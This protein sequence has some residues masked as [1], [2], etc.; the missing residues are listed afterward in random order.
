MK[1]LRVLLA[2]DHTLVRAGLRSLLQQMENVEVVAEAEDGRQVLAAV[3]EHRPDVVLMDISMSG[4]NGLE[5]T[6]QLKRDRPEVRVIILSMHATEEYVLQA[7]RAGAS[8]YLLKD[9]A[10]LELALALQAVARG[11]SYLSPPVSRQVV[12][13][14]VQRTGRE[15]QP[16]AALTPRQREILQLIAEG[17]STKEIASRLALSVKTVETHRSQLMERLSIRGVAGLVRYAIRHG[18]V[19]AHK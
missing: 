3:A 10:P 19:S 8:G 9:S 6:L 7:L 5:A 12:E 17:N 2:D 13:S 18:L 14:Y 11:E 1:T 16:L 4:M 15:A